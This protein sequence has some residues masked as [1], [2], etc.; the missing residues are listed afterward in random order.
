MRFV[1]TYIPWAIHEVA[2]G[3]L[4][5]GEKDPQRDVAAFIRMAG[6]LGLFVIARPGPH[7]NAELTYFGIPD[8]V[9]WDPACQARSPHQNPVILPMIPA[10]FP[11]PSYVSNVFHEETARWFAEVGK[12]LVPLVYPAGPIVSFQV[13][14][15]GALYFR[16]G[17]YDQDYHPDAIDR[18][19]TFLREKYGTIEALVTAYG[20]VEKA[21]SIFG[22]T[23]EGA[24]TFDGVQPPKR[25][26]ATTVADLARHIDWAEFQERLLAGAIERF[27][28]AMDRAGLKGVPRTHNF[29]PGQDATPLNAARVSTSRGVD[30]VGYDYYNDASE[31][32]RAVIARRT[33]ELAV[34]CTA[35][36]VRVR[37]GRRISAVLSAARRERQRV[38]GAHR[39]RVRAPR[40]QRVH[41][42]RA[43]PMDRLADRQG[44]P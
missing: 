9:V 8:R 3:V 18:Y 26:D 4:E 36:G 40:V 41:G 34:R 16:D 44:G 39:A 32:S 6:E 7:I 12:V 23:E 33:T 29:P 22:T 43:R 37:D 21:A 24:R 5:L 14:N 42:R 31:T 17:V 1:D 11:V 10:A 20:G 19:R 38:H 15:E 30:L 25:F 13:D 2:P 35:L 27:S 28:D